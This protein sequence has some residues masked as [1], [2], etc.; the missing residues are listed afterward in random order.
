MTASS[1]SRRLDRTD[2]GFKSVRRGT[3][4]ICELAND[5]NCLGRP[6]DLHEFVD[7]IL[8][9]LQH[10]QELDEFA[11]RGPQIIRCSFGLINQL[12]PLIDEVLLFLPRESGFLLERP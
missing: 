7:K 4:V 2:E 3:D 5:F 10:A 9:G 8:A 11:A 1:D 6:P 12:T